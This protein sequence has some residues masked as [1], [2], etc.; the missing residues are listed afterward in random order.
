MFPGTLIGSR[1]PRHES[2]SDQ[3]YKIDR[4][5]T[6]PDQCI[7][8]I[9]VPVDYGNDLGL[10]RAYRPGVIV[11]M[12]GLAVITTELLIRPSVTDLASA[13]KAD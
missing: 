6:F 3:I 9:V 7:Q 4:I 2:H 12:P 13:F 11:M 10:E 1:H 8:N 5:R